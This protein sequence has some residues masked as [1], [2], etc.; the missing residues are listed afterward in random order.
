MA[1]VQPQG[2]RRPAAK[3]DSRSNTDTLDAGR[4]HGDS[5]VGHRS[6][7][8]GGEHGDAT[9]RRS[10]ASPNDG[11][12]TGASLASLS[13]ASRTEQDWSI[14]FPGRARR[15]PSQASEPRGPDGTSWLDDAEDAVSPHEQTSTTAAPLHDGTGQFGHSVLTDTTSGMLTASQDS[16]HDLFLDPYEGQS[17]TESGGDL[18]F[19]LGLDFEA[20]ASTSGSSTTPPPSLPAS[21]DDASDDASWMHRRD[22]RTFELSGLETASASS[23]RTP[24]SDDFLG[25]DVEW[26]WQDHGGERILASTTPRQ[27]SPLPDHPRNVRP[28]IDEPDSDEEPNVS[29]LRTSRSRARAASARVDDAAFESEFSATPSALS[30]G[31]SSRDRRGVRQSTISQAS[32][33]R[34]SAGYKRRQRRQHVGEEDSVR[35]SKSRRS[36]NYAS[37]CLRPIGDRSGQKRPPA[38]PRAS[39]QHTEASASGDSQVA[40]ASTL[41]RRQKASRLI[42]RI[43]D[44]DNDVLQSVVCDQGPLALTARERQEGTRQASSTPRQFGVSDD[45]LANGSSPVSGWRELIDGRVV[46]DDQEPFDHPAAPGVDDA[47]THNPILSL[48]RAEEASEQ[49]LRTSDGNDAGESSQ[50]LIDPSLPETFRHA[51]LQ[52]TASEALTSSAML[53]STVDAI[54]GVMPY[55]VPFSWRLIMKM[56]RDWNATSRVDSGHDGD[57]K[58][59]HEA[60]AEDETENSTTTG[61]LTEGKVASLADTAPDKAAVKVERWR[62]RSDSLLSEE[63]LHVRSD[64]GLAGSSAASP[65]GRAASRRS[66]RPYMLQRFMGPVAATSSDATPEALLTSIASSRILLAYSRV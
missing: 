61:S 63:F 33:S 34:I 22:A 6:R 64:A 43:F 13:S 41:S 23:S 56:V 12:L 3:T 59:V 29:T 36:D 51:L 20:A 26:S 60:A 8:I 38:S 4:S 21:R 47:H 10:I 24:P 16:M 27:R 37:A 28:V 9:W 32:S 66:S 15:L 18:D 53:S 62:E 11:A 44:I 7:R 65:P 48:V 31:L 17:E 55:F 45:H 30:A 54:Q 19:D 42:S 5:L 1:F 39:G 35:S 40:K 25:E 52:L 57:P 46:K 58:P 14:V 2:F 49:S 50:G